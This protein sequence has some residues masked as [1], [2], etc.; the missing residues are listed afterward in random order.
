MCVLVRC[1]TIGTGERMLCGF[2]TCQLFNQL[3]PGTGVFNPVMV[4]PFSEKDDDDHTSVFR[5]Q[6]EATMCANDEDSR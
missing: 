2:L 3:Q 6:D 1:G 5:L 4:T